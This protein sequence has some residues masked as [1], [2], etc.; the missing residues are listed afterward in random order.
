MYVVRCAAVAPDQYRT[1]WCLW[2]QGHWP[3]C[4]HYLTAWYY[5]CFLPSLSWHFVTFRTL[6]LS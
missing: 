6:F 3:F 1:C 2:K 5:I 4:S